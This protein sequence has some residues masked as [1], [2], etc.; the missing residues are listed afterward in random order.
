MKVDVHLD[1]SRYQ[2]ANTILTVI[3]HYIITCCEHVM[4]TINTQHT[5]YEQNYRQQ[6]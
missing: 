1:D 6:E 2:I 4:F 5:P 3:K